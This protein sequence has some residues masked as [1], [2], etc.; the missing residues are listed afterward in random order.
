MTLEFVVQP[1][2]SLTCPICQECYKNPVII[3][4]CNHTFCKTCITQSLEYESQCP[5]CRKK[6]LKTDYH[7]NLA[8]QGLVNELLV[9]CP[10]RTIGCPKQIPLDQLE[11]HQKA[12]EFAPAACPYAK[13]GCA[14]SGTHSQLE[15]H[16]QVCAFHQLRFFI[17]Q[18]ENR[19]SELE[20]MNEIQHKKLEILYEAHFNRKMSHNEQETMEPINQWP[21]GA[22]E[23][24]KTI[25]ST[26]AG[27]S[28]LAK[29]NKVLYAGSY[30][31]KIQ[32]M[33]LDLGSVV[34]TL[35]GHRLSVWSLAVHQETNRL[36]SASSDEII[37]VWDISRPMAP[38]ETI[39][40]ESS[41]GKVYSLLIHNNLLFSASSNGII[42]IWDLSSYTCVGRLLGHAGGVNAIKVHENK[43]YS[44]SSDRSI[45]IWDIATQTLEHTIGHHPSEVLDVCIES[46]MVFGSTYDANIIAYNLN[47]YSR[48][49]TLSG[50][51]W[52]VWKLQRYDGYLFS[53]SHDHTIKRWDLR[54]L[55]WNLELTGHKGYIHALDASADGLVSGGADKTIKLWS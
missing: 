34:G 12:C 13:H 50:H 4:A 44:A 40:L 48:I 16:L 33:D 19:I 51:K 31:G 24:K 17:E 5:V 14:F 8:L 42:K 46:G 32:S 43:L 45:R 10:Y 52:E 36:F 54:S 55:A 47:D 27:I 49:S 15:Q 53:G 26:G 30:D 21:A 28:A 38:R 18:T 3:N 35:D 20:K 2:L 7:P 37:K 9:Y 11:Q 6:I 1:S 23:C 41:Q 39:S 29:N 25:L 22:I